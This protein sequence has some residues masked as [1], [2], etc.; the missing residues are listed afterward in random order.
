[1]KEKQII[2]YK[3]AKTNWQL[4]VAA[5]LFSI[6]ILI[7]VS[8]FVEIKIAYMEYLYYSHWIGK[9]FLLVFIL[10][11]AIHNSSS[12]IFSFDLEKMLCKKQFSVG[13]INYG[14]WKKL[15]HIEYVSIH[16]QPLKNGTVYV[17][18]INLWLKKNRHL[19]ISRYADLYFENAFE[20][21]FQI[22]NA[23]KFSYLDSTAELSQNWD[24]V[25]LH[26]N[27]DSLIKTHPKY[28]T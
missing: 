9:V 21:G 2:I 23:L 12:I 28:S 7:I 16:K 15:Q 18:D 27:V 5:I 11:A 22:A 4:F 26:K 19:T 25:D 8:F 17:F 20:M 10:P 3:G 24:W 13:P 6:S 1:M 14:K